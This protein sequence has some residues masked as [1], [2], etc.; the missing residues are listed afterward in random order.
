MVCLIIGLAPAYAQYSY[1]KSP[2]QYR[3]DRQAQIERDRKKLIEDETMAIVLELYGSLSVNS[4]GKL[5]GRLSLVQ[6]DFSLDAISKAREIF[7]SKG[8]LWG[9]TI[10][11]QYRAYELYIKER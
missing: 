7:E 6:G 3:A 8:W 11:N 9:A 4:N 1:I 10:P 2:E 5:E